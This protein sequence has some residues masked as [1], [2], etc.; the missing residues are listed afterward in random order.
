MRTLLVALGALTFWAS[1]GSAQEIDG[2]LRLHLEV[3]VLGYRS[4]EVTADGADDGASV[5]RVSVG[6]GTDT[7]GFGLGYGLSDMLVLGANM[8][9]Q[10]TSVSPEEGASASTT[11]VQLLPYLEVLFGEGSTRPFIGGNLILQISSGENT[12]STLFGLGALG[13]VHVFLNE[14]VSFDVSARL[15]YMTGTV[16]VDTGIVESDTDLSELGVLLLLGVSG[17]S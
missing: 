14:W 9:L 5:S 7:L 6:P 2:S 11:V 17:W 4:T 15:Y 16:T 3:P 1:T 12:D 8:A 13:G 10:H